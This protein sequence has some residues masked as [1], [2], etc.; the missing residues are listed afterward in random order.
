MCDFLATRPTFAKTRGVVQYMFDGKPIRL[1]VDQDDRIQASIGVQRA[2]GSFG[3][4][5]LDLTV[6]RIVQPFTSTE[7]R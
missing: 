4:A 5:H 3:R 7:T 6:P 1:R 2:D